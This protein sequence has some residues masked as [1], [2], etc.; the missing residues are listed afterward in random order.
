MRAEQRWL[1]IVNV[2]GRRASIRRL[3]VERV[4]I[5]VDPHVRCAT[6][7]GVQILWIR[8]ASL[9]PRLRSLRPSYLTI[10]STHLATGIRSRDRRIN[11]LL[12]AS[13][14]ACTIAEI[15]VMAVIADTKS[16]PFGS[17]S[18]PRRRNSIEF[19]SLGADMDDCTYNTSR[20]RL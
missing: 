12:T 17:T 14:E 7:L 11:Q 16:R 10:D 5:P 2:A 18:F 4:F 13:K 8:L 9:S 19:I 6:A 1:L 20:R 15:S 3:H